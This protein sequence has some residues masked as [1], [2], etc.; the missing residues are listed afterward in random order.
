MNLI[1]KSLRHFDEL[2]I[3]LAQI[4]EFTIRIQKISWVFPLAFSDSNELCTFWVNDI[5]LVAHKR[6]AYAKKTVVYTPFY[7]SAHIRLQQ[8][9]QQNAWPLSCTHCNTMLDLKSYLILPSSCRILCMMNE[10]PEF[11]YVEHVEQCLHM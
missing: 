2:K 11:A 1:K 4:S 6:I 7:H 5:H 9:Q 10:T 3:A 8:Q